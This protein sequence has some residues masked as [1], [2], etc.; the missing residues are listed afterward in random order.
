[1]EYGMVP[2]VSIWR[3]LVSSFPFVSVILPI[4]NEAACI[5]RGLRVILAQ[6]Y[7]GPVETLIADGMST[8]DTRDRIQSIMDGRMDT[9]SRPRSSIMV[10]DNPGKTSPKGMNTALRQAKGEIIVRVDGH[11]VIAPD[12][13]RQCV[14]SI[15]RTHADNVGGKM[16]AIGSSPFGRSV[17]LAT[18][19]PFGIGGGRFHTSDKEEW[20]D[21]VYMGA[22]PRSVFKKIGLFDEELVRDQDDEF[23]YRLREQ[24]GR[25]LLC[26][27]IR[28]EYTV[29]SSPMALWKQYYQ[30]GYWKVRVL[31]KHP[32]QMSLRQFVPPAFV[33]SL[34]LS[35][36]LALSA[37]LLPITYQLLSPP[38]PVLSGFFGGSAISYQLSSPCFILLSTCWYPSSP[39]PSAAGNV[40]LSCR[41]SLPFYI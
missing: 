8:D 38:V 18:S 34:L 32:H 9:V 25:I 13:V 17:A 20:V 12:Y 39:P 33:L 27:G 10:L 26:P 11:T 22:W 7:S 1:M 24:G 3:A 36:L 14:E 2:W 5:E 21:T 28:S 35:L 19:T 23:N 6:D 4:R 15:Q 31:Q 30:Y 40:C 41:S 29:R 37:L 16:N